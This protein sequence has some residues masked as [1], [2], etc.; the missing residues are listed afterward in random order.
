MKLR[1]A[2]YRLLAVSLPAMWLFAHGVSFDSVARVLLT[3]LLQASI[4]IS[5]LNW[6]F[7]LADAPPPERLLV[8]TAVGFILTTTLDQVLIAAG[9]SGISLSLLSVLSLLAI[10]ASRSS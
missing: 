2:I 4:G 7:A 6:P 10:L 1:Q 5:I 9:F 8:G 3:L